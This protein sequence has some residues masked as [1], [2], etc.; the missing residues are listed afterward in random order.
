MADFIITTDRSLPLAL[1]QSWTPVYSTSRYCLAIEA[2]PTPHDI[3]HLYESPYIVVALSHTDTPRDVWRAMRSPKDGDSRHFIDALGVCAGIVWNT[4][5]DEFCVF[6]DKFGWI[7]ILATEYGD[8]LSI[9]SSPQAHAHI[10]A[11]RDIDENWFAR[12]LYGSNE[13]RRNDVWRQTSRLYPGEVRLW[14]GSDL[15][16]FLDLFGD[17]RGSG[18][19]ESGVDARSDMYWHRRRYAPLDIS[20]DEAVEALRACHAR[21]IGRIPT[22][23][24]PIFTLSGGL[25]STSIVAA[26]ARATGATREHPIETFSLLSSRHASCDES[27]EIDVLAQA[28][29]ITAHRLDMGLRTDIGDDAIASNAHGYG[30]ICSPGLEINLW[31][32]RQMAPQP[33]SRTIITGYGGNFIVKARVE[34]ILG[35]LW[36]YRKFGELLNYANNVRFSTYRYLAKRYITYLL[37]KYFGIHKTNT[38]EAIVRKVCNREFWMRNENPMFDNIFTSTQY[39]ERASMPLCDEWEYMMRAIDITARMSKQYFYDPLFDAELYDFCAQIPPHY[40]DYGGKDRAVYRAAFMPLLPEA[41]RTHPKVQSFDE[42]IVD[43]VNKNMARFGVDFNV[44]SRDPSIID[45]TELKKMQSDFVE[46]RQTEHL[47][48]VW[49]PTAVDWW[50][51]A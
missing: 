25:D 21:A 20:F 41:I 22:T 26:Y 10:N 47:S 13:T 8:Y 46:R 37:A 15:G 33:Y 30:P 51:R 14:G 28:L 45:R 1:G 48:D 50:L 6:R 12:F 31:T 19:V 32:Y 35:D 3:A 29:P 4:E 42:A 5:T 17:G 24:P 40:W 23:K 39:Q 27:T 2:T 49:R 11:Q 44:A 38:S 36:K 7:P 16:A 9:T 18:G 34:A 43:I